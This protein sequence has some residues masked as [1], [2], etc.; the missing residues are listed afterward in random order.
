MSTILEIFNTFLKSSGVSIDS[1]TVEKDNIFFAISGD[2]FD[3]HD[4]IGNA[5]ESGAIA[6]VIDNP[7]YQNF[8]ELFAKRD[9]SPPIFCVTDTINTLQQLARMYRDTFQIPVLG[10]TGSNGK[11]T[12]KELIAKV[13]SKKYQVHSTKGN[14]NNHLGVPLTLLAMPIDTQV[15][16]IEMGANHLGEI[17]DLCMIADPNVGLITNIGKA[18]IGEFGSFENI[19][20]TKQALFSHVMENANG[21]I[22]VN[23]EDDQLNDIWAKESENV[24]T[25]S[26]HEIMF[27][28]SEETKIT[29]RFKEMN[30]RNR[31]IIQGNTGTYNLESK[32]YGRYNQINI[33]AAIAC[34]AYWSI[35]VKEIADA[36][37][38]YI[39]QN[40]RSQVLEIDTNTI[41]LDTYNANPDSMKAAVDEMVQLNSA[42]KV[43]ILGDMLE[44]GIYAEDEHQ[45]LLDLVLQQD[46][47]EIYLVGQEFPLEKGCK[48]YPDWQSLKQK[49]DFTKYHQTA[50]LIKGSRSI[51]LENLV[52]DFL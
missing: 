33:A 2:N 17:A 41:L 47:N 12:T 11:T 49:L 7:S 6:A 45:R 27:N 44:L 3:G 48:Y 52:S 51:A 24:L 50:F 37:E 42:H 4:Y 1:R 40:K 22:L 38:E 32:L 10:I 23:I 35:P 31:V 36:I 43:L 19:V 16:I 13:I 28:Q 29:L 26:T 9:L 18:H 34:G 39:P 21:T 8:S 25:Y 20:Q 46:F 5:L 15:A 14:L 30:L